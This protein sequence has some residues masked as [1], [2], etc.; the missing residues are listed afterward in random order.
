MSNYK[1]IFSDL[2]GTLLSDRH[3][4]SEEN[5]EAIKKFSEM[6][7]I[8]VPTSGRAESEFPSSLIDNPYIRYYIFSDGSVIWD[9]FT[10]T[11]TA[12]YI[13]NKKTRQIF[14]FMTAHSG[15]IIVHTNKYAYIDVNENFELLNTAAKQYFK[16]S[17]PN[18]NFKD[19]VL[20]SEKTELIFAYFEEQKELEE[21]Y[22]KIY[23]LGGVEIAS[24]AQNSFEVVSDKAGKSSS[25]L[26][27]AEMLGIDICDVIAVGDNTNDSKMI[28]AAG[29]GLAV[30]NAH[31]E[32]KQVANRVICSH[33]EHIVSYILENVL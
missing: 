13:S 19:T 5:L 14:E 16:N 29:L 6:G 31:P 18:E 15:K 22:E 2:D 10:N 30:E 9:K 27:L 11:Y 24:S 1:I 25:M 12:N 7:G 26:A 32:L 33:K 17:T 8:F 21:C 4:V 23:A 28:K 3:T 20:S